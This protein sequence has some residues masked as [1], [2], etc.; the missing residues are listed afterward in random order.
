[1]PQEKQPKRQQQKEDKDKQ[2]KQKK[3]P[4]KEGGA[5]VSDVKNLAVPFAIL[6][7][8]EGLTKYFKDDKKSSSKSSSKSA[9]KKSTK[10]SSST[11]SR[12]RT[13]AGGSCNLGCGAM[14]GGAAAKQ[15]MQLQQQI[16]NFLEKY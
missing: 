16:D 7:A 2:Q 11:L 4:K 3:A 9:E 1:M 15:L 12:R 5:F 13:M 6:L 10:T 8:K 14:T